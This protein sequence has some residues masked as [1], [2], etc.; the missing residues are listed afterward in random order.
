[1]KTWS[2]ISLR[3]FRKLQNLLCFFGFQW[4]NNRLKMMS[5]SLNDQNYP[6]YPLVLKLNVTLAR[7]LR[8]VILYFFKRKILSDDRRL[9]LHNSKWNSRS[10]VDGLTHTKQLL[11]LLCIVYIKVNLFHFS[12]LQILVFNP[13]HDEYLYLLHSFT[14]SVLVILFLLLMTP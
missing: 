7:L 4:P 10:D 6:H 14:F 1:M 3:K 2:F 9:Y 5:A 8:L 11:N 12:Y 13:C